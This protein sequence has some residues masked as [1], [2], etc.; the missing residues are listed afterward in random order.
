MAVTLATSLP[1]TQ[2][3]EEEPYEVVDGQKVWPVVAETESDAIYEV[4]DGERREVPRMGVFAGSLASI[5][6]QY[7]GFFA[8][9]H[10]LGVAVVEV[11]FRLCSEPKRERR[12]DVAFVRSDRLPEAAVLVED[13]AAWDAVPNL[14]VEI[15]SPT[16]G[17]LEI[18][19]KIHDYFRA[20]VEWVWVVYPRHRLIYVYQSPHENRILREQDE[21]EGEALLPGFRVKVADLFAPLVKS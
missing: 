10:K 21:L 15:V 1:A 4:I 8:L 5:L 6:C 7:M 13:P 3:A 14:A 18:M 19:D 20:G 17:A 11:T 2:L 16:N 12:P 9:Q